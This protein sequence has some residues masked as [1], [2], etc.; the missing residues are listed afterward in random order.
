MTDAE[1]RY[2][3][4]EFA[5]IMEASAGARLPQAGHALRPC[6]QTF[7]ALRAASNCSGRT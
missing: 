7:S 2:T 1:R 6:R 5:G 4:Q 3:D